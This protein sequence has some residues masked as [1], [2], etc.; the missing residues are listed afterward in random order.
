MKRTGVVL[1]AALL[2]ACGA[3]PKGQGADSGR[4]ELPGPDDDWVAVLPSIPPAPPGEPQMLA[5]VT[6]SFFF[7]D[8]CV[9]LST[10]EGEEPALILWPSGTT[11]QRDAQGMFVSVGGNKLREGDR[12][13]SSGGWVPLGG[14]NNPFDIPAR[15]VAEQGVV[16]YSPVRIDGEADGPPPSEPPPPRGNG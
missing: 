1:A 8:D 16:V 13:I 12:L 14:P 2:G 6:G 3:T 10:S 5:R 7:R 9:W 11:L 4:L 15:C